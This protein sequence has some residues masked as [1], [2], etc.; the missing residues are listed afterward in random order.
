MYYFGTEQNTLQSA[1]Q[2]I[3]ELGKLFKELYSEKVTLVG[4][5]LTERCPLMSVH[6]TCLDKT[7]PNILFTPGLPT[8]FREKPKVTWTSTEYARFECALNNNE[9]FRDCGRGTEGMWTKDRVSEGIH[10]FFVRGTDRHGNVGPTESFRFS[11]GM[12]VLLLKYVFHYIFRKEEG[13]WFMP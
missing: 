5:T 11:I 1:D 8:K 7:S 10:D 3:F 2:N 12:F 6:F 13:Y 9:Q 4:S